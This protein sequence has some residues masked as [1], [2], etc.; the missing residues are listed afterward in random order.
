MSSSSFSA[1]LLRWHRRHGRHDLPWQYTGDPYHV[2]LSEIMLQQTQVATV[3]PYYRRFVRRFPNV[4]ALAAAS[5]DEVLKLWAGL[6]YYA[7]A[8]HL[9]RCA[10]EIVNQH[11][12][13]WPRDLG[14]LRGLPGIG[15][16]TAGAILA[17]AHNFRHPILDGNVR[18]VLARYHAVRGYPGESGIEKK[19]W[20]LAEAHLS[21]RRIAD[22]TQ[23]IMDLGATVCTRRRPDCPHCPLRTDCRANLAGNPEAYPTPRPKH[24][25]PVK[26]TRFL[27]L[28]DTR[29]R[30]WLQRRPARGIWGGLWSFPE[31]AGQ[32]NEIRWCREHLGLETKPLGTL[33]SFRHSFTHFHLD[34][35]PE[36]RRVTRRTRV[37][38]PS[39]GIWYNNNDELPVGVATPVR[40]LL[41]VL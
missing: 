29:N 22:Y 1:R 12:G 37:M 4:H 6:G 35:H 7:R 13:R 18:R 26:S 32:E 15:R 41:A 14:T 23:A 34:I 8:R 20:Y 36:C 33:P 27:I 17:L 24:R 9:H 16:S 3:I 25:L 39:E 21:Y 31:L 40:R 10:Q 5:L 28:R 11:R 2:W 30:V 19:L 38:A